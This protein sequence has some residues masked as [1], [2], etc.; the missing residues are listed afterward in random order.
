MPRSVSG[1]GITDPREIRALKLITARQFGILLGHS[2]STV[3]KWIRK[4]WIH[5]FTALDTN[6]LLI[7]IEQVDAFLSERTE[8]ERANRAA[9]LAGRGRR[10]TA[11]RNPCHPVRNI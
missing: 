6:S 1:N 10:A 5:P 7:P 4:G 9:I 3:E 8:E 2:A 11:A